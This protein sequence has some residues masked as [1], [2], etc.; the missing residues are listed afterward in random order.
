MSD[1]I[2]RRKHGKTPA[3]ARAAVEHMVAELKTAFDLSYAWKN[4][5]QHDV[6]HFKR[7]GLSGVLAIEGE[8]AALNIQLGFLLSALKP[9][10]EQKVH[11]FFDENFAG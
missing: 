6:M 2:I 3:E 4:N 7:P 9:V 1:I 5:G 8:D 10:I 11:K